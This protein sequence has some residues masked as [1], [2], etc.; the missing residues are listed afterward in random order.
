MGWKRIGKR[1]VSGSVRAAKGAGDGVQKFQGWQEKQQNIS[2]AK[3]KRELKKLDMD[4]KIAK[5]KTQ[6]KKL[7]PSDDW[8]LGI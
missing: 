8:D 7:K 6:L 3:R 2:I 5:K 1:I 4:V